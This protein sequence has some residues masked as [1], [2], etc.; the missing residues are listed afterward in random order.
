[1]NS[2]IFQLWE[3][4]IMPIYLALIMGV[5]YVIAPKDER[6]LFMWALS[7][8]IAGALLFASIYLFYYGGGDTIAYYLTAKPFI[9]LMFDRP[10]EAIEALFSAYSKENYALFD[11][12]T[13]YPLKYI[14]VDNQTFTV[15]RVISPILLISLNRYLPATLVLCALSFIG[16]WKLYEVFKDAFDN[17]RIAAIAALF[18]PSV[19]FWGTGISKDTVTFTSAAYLIYGFYFTVIKREVKIG[20]V[21]GS[22]I[23][24]YLIMAIKPYIFIALLPGIFLWLMSAPIAK[25]KSNFVRRFTIPFIAIISSLLFIFAFQQ[26]NDLLGDYSADQ[27]LEKALIT[28]E[29][30][31]RDYY[32]GNSF[33]IGEVDRSFVG[34][35][36][37]FPIATFYGLYSPTIFDV[38]NIVMLFS[39]LENTILIYLTL[40][41]LFDF[42]F[43]RLATIMLDSPILSFCLV[44]TLLF[45]FSIGFTTPNYG[46][47]VRF[48]IP[49]LPFLVFYLLVIQ[50]LLSNP[51]RHTIEN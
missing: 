32:G 25:V 16:P 41:I 26:F 13:G 14:Y 24:L 34:V 49:L 46:A 50:K 38:R 33:D 1:M 10:L 23:A 35:L 29:D 4:L 30:L 3:L 11:Q 42:K 44:F 2:D 27:I 43:R 28:Q 12:N 7:A 48:K 51:S 17:K 9:S 47:M 22:G 21:I 39:A 5:A 45:A 18:I 8:R 20:R 15:S 6:T 19:L 31:K 40:R 36:S 37:K